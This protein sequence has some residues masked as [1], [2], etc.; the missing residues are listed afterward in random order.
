MRTEPLP[1]PSYAR[2]GPHEP[3]LLRY[4]TPD[5]HVLSS[6][7]AMCGKMRASVAAV[8]A[9]RDAAPQ[10]RLFCVAQSA[11][12]PLLTA[13]V[14]DRAHLWDGCHHYSG[15][16]AL[17]GSRWAR[18][19][20][21]PPPA[22]VLPVPTWALR[23]PPSDAPQATPEPVSF[24]VL[25]NNLA[26]AAHQREIVGP[27]I[28]AVDPS[29]VLP[30]ETWDLAATQALVPPTYALVQGAVTGQGRGLAAGIRLA[31]IL[32][33]HPPHGGLRLSRL[34]GGPVPRPTRGPSAPAGRPL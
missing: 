26:G 5:I 31:D 7:C 27:L 18:C 29:Y 2:R 23:L 28:E 3:W 19:M 21:L 20:G 22:T 33:M 6:A 17:F 30:Q 11:Q 24:W 13:S 32:P 12:H 1:P 15:G 8:L 9:P 34:G 4:T 16:I 25:G 10:P 14:A